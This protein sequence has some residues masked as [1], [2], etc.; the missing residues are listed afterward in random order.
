MRC[1]QAMRGR[2]SSVPLPVLRR[3]CWFPPAM[4]TVAQQW[5]APRWLVVALLLSD[6]AATSASPSTSDSEGMRASS[7]PPL[8]SRHDPW[9][10]LRCVWI[11][12]IALLIMRTHGAALDR[13]DTKA[14]APA[15]YCT[16]RR[17]DAAGGWARAYEGGTS[18][19][20]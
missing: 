13:V 16:G 3:R 2:R 15:V 6:G 10:F 20:R 19:Q 5:V 17:P 9:R 14:L 12:V 1:H 4:R 11:C 7:A 8:P 18:A